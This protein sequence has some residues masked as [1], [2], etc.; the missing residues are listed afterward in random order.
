MLS[1]EFNRLIDAALT[2]GVLTPKEREV[3]HKKAL[4]E[5]LDPDE[6]DVI[7]ESR[8]QEIQ[9][10]AQSVANKVR[11]CPYCGSLLQPGDV[12]CP[13]CGNALSTGANETAMKFSEGLSDVMKWG[14][15]SKQ[16]M[17]I[18]N[19]PLSSS[20]DDLLAML[21]ALQPLAHKHPNV[22]SSEEEQN[23]ERAYWS[24]YSDCINKAKLNFA[25]DASF[26]TYFTSYQKESR[27]LSHK[28]LKRL[29]IGAIIA[30]FLILSIIAG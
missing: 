23:I 27:K 5:G 1:D 26:A 12:K 14:D 2:D 10:K 7:I 11:K 29:I 30:I 19:F 18:R 9:M 17:Y 16:A 25:D 13:Q 21:S 28:Q 6:V 8:L 3:I 15:A 24:K 22:N 20:R 4:L